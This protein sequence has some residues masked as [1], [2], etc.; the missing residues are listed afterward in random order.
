MQPHHARQGNP[1]RLQPKP[2]LPL[3]LHHF[4]ARLSQ[5][6]RQPEPRQ[7]RKLQPAM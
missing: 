5:P 2:E 7:Q 3:T 6:P 4:G 1:F